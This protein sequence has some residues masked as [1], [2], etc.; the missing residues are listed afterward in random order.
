[1][2]PKTKE[3]EEEHIE[4]TEETET[5]EK[6]TGTDQTKTGKTFTQED[7]NKIVAKE[8]AAWK[9]SAD[10]EKTTL[11]ETETSLREQITARDEVIQTNVDLLR[12]DLDIN[13]EDWEFMSDGKD[14]LAQYEFLLKK[15]E[16]SGKQDIPRTPAGKRKQPEFTSTFNANV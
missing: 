7:V 16:K 9:R 8:K 4:G 3:V 1:M 5:E 15:I 2:E 13:D 12:K 14:A 6:V 10:K 11:S